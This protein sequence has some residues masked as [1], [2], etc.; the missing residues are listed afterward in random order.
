MDEQ[1]P[2]RW[3]ED[4]RSEIFLCALLGTALSLLFVWPLI[5]YLSND[6]INYI[7]DV[8]HLEK[9]YA[10]SGRYV[11]AALTFLLGFLREEVV[12]L[13]YA[14][15]VFNIA[16]SIGFV[17]YL[18]SK[19]DIVRDPVTAT[20][21]ATMVATFPLSLDLF[22]FNINAIV[23]SAHFVFCILLVWRLTL[24]KPPRLDLLLIGIVTLGLLNYQSII[25]VAA[26]LVLIASAWRAKSFSDWIQLVSW[27]VANLLIA[28]I[29]YFVI[30]ASIDY[31]VANVLGWKMLT[32]KEV[33]AAAV[34]DIPDRFVAFI[35]K[36]YRVFLG[37]LRQF[38][39]GSKWVIYASMAI[40]LLVWWRKT[41]E[42]LAQWP[43]W[44]IL[45]RILTVIG[46]VIAAGNPYAIVT[47]VGLFNNRQ[48][49]H[50][51]IVFAV[52]AAT[53]I[54][55]C[56]VLWL[57]RTLAAIAAFAMATNAAVLS[58]EAKR[59]QNTERNIANRVIM[60]VEAIEDFNSR[61]TPVG[62]YGNLDL[63]FFDVARRS[64]GGG[65]SP[66]ITKAAYSTMSETA[67]YEL[68]RPKIALSRRMKER[69]GELQKSEPRGVFWR[70]E[71][72]DKA[73][74]VCFF[75]FKDQN[76]N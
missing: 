5:S 21:L 2:T 11:A 63:I 48:W 28:L 55:A 76:K 19:I 12:H 20:L 45:V 65:L 51:G 53:A 33:S 41:N 23:Q 16:L 44:R 14:I 32:I 13:G 40:A 43:T 46:L 70:V 42:P 64:F 18:F 26:A 7:R 59:L 15:R 66:R 49:G 60:Q 8:P 39:T 38:N 27:A 1:S 54:A 56:P 22:A 35:R 34:A 29:A 71:R 30:K 69:C 75:R 31:V 61:R 9:V 3:L 36:V 62:V 72:F 57:Q 52:F 68:R 4:T 10:W 17:L 25:M 58:F 6:D 74:I 67:G 24:D 47:T 50:G 73:V 37:D